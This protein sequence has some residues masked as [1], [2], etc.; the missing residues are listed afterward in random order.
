MEAKHMLS[1]NLINRYQDE[2]RLL[3]RYAKWARWYNG[4]QYPLVEGSVSNKY[5]DPFV[6]RIELGAHFP[7]Q[8]PY[9]YVM[10]P[11]R[12]PKYGSGYVNDEGC[13]HAFHTHENGPNG[14]VSI[15]HTSGWNPSMTLVSVLFRGIIWINA[16]GLHRRTGK[17]LCDCMDTYSLQEI[18]K[19]R[20]AL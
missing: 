2:T 9:L 11:R 8:E 4:N 19:G 1:I 17:D 18:A 20:I 3:R 12:L 13:S 7:H 16:Y 6:L 14:L 10:S 5:G 15:C